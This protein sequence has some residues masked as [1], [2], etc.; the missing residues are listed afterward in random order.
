MLV[1]PGGSRSNRHFLRFPLADVGEADPGG[2]EGAR[3]AQGP[4]QQCEFAPAWPQ[5][6]VGAYVCSAGSI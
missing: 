5:R 4:E 1:L 6:S 3:A 2:S